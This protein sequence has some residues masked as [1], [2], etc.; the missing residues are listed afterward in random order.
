MQ[1]YE[2]KAGN[3]FIPQLPETSNLKLEPRNF[4]LPVVGGMGSPLSFGAF[5]GNEFAEYGLFGAPK[6]T[7]EKD[8]RKHSHFE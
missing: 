8:H 6:S 3:L 4:K 1:I 2:K 7:E 5:A